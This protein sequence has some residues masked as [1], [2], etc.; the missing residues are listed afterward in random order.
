MRSN[1]Q[2]SKLEL[3]AA[4]GMEFQDHDLRD[5]VAQIAQFRC[6]LPPAAGC[7]GGAPQPPQE[8]DILV[9]NTHLLFNPKRGDIKVLFYS[10]W[11][12]PRVLHDKI[13]ENPLWHS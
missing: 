4:S 8:F 11:G 1:R 5:N 2:A 6:T 9:A 12:L 10:V 13:N 7:D 3:A